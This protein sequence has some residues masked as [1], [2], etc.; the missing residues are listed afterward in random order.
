MTNKRPFTPS[1]KQFF[2]KKIRLMLL[3]E[4]NDIPRTKVV[5]F[6]KQFFQYGIE[7]KKN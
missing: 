2:E 7:F 3:G 4:G 1:E 5:D 6:C